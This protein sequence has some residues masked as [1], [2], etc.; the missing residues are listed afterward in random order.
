VHWNKT[1]QQLHKIIFE[2]D[3]RLGKLFDVFL[4]IFIVISMLAVMLET[5]GS[6][7]AKYHIYFIT[8]E[9]IIT[10]LFTIEYCLRIYSVKKPI[11]YIFSFYGIIDFL[12]ILPLYLSLFFVGTQTFAIIRAIRL[13]RIFRVFKLGHFLVESKVLVNSLRKSMTKITIFMYFVTLMVVIFGSIM[14]LIEGGQNET[15]DS[16]PRGIYWAIVTLTTVGYGDISPVTPLGQFVASIVMILGYAVIAVPT[17][18]ISSEFIK[19]HNNTKES[20][21][22]CPNCMKEDHDVHAVFCK[23]CG[24]KLN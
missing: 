15:F 2:A 20:T 22:A 3:T 14:Y 12:S 10:I 9:W 11:N 24:G 13:L 6:A 23:Y 4:L 5:I 17:G 16:I 18:I 7:D 8:I 21:E 1:R 19:G